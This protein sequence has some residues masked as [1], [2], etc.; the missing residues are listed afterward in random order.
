MRMSAGSA[1]TRR[2]SAGSRVPD[3]FRGFGRGTVSFR[4][5]AASLSRRSRSC[6]AR[7]LSRLQTPRA[8]LELTG[9]PRSGPRPQSNGL[10]ERFHK[11]LFDEHLRVKGR[12]T[13]YEALDEMQADLKEYRERHNPHRARKMNGGNIFTVFPA[14]VPKAL[15]AASSNS[16]PTEDQQAA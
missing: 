7:R 2:A 13:W 10:I 4:L 11:T 8:P 5:A 16:S 12:I 3:H 6:L 1:Q 9:T 15:K 14:G